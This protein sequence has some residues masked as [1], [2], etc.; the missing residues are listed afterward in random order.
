ML[1]IVDTPLPEVKIIEGRRFAD[2]RGYFTELS[3]E[4]VLSRA[5]RQPLHFVQH[6]LS[7]S[8]QGVL[9]GVHYQNPCPQGKLISCLQGEIWD[10]AVDLRRSSPNFGRWTAVY[11]SGEQPRQLWIP[12]GFGHGFCV[13]RGD[14]LV[15]YQCTQEYAPEH[16]HCVNYADETLQ[17]PW[18]VQAESLVLSP[19]DSAA[20]RLQDQPLFA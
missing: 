10:V 19:K 1:K 2:T 15:F 17:L 9:R 14:A 16:E 8:H 11:L 18:P 3:H 4:S 5:L 7:L 20:P 13:T 12:E 6:N